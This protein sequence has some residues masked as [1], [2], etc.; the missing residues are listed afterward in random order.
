MTDR[1]EDEF[2]AKWEGWLDDANEWKP[3]FASVAEISTT[4]VRTALVDHAL[5]EPAE[6]EVANSLKRSAERISVQLPNAF[7]RDRSS[8]ALL[9]LGFALSKVGDLAIPYS[10]LE[11]A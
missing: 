7:S 10:R 5:V 9:A 2:D 3:F 1:I 4:D 8:V 6:V 11:A